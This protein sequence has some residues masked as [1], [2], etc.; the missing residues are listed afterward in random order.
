MLAHARDDSSHGFCLP[1]FVQEEFSRYLC[2][3]ILAAGGFVRLRCDDCGDER[4]LPFSCKGRAVCPS[5]TTRR[6]HDVAAHLCSRVLPHVPYRQWVLSLPRHVRFRL[7]R[8]PA[9]LSRVLTLFLRAVFCWQ[10]RRARA[11]GVARPLCGS[12]TFV[13]RFGY[14]RS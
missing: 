13:Q 7:A 9:R 5:C 11:A 10:R 3:G 6:M 1:R 4:L 2:C 8:D 12:I 14:R